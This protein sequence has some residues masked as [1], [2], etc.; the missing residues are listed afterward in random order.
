V[1]ALG[2]FIG[3][4]SINALSDA[5]KD[6]LQMRDSVTR[7]A[8]GV[9]SISVDLREIRSEITTQVGALKVE[10]HE[11]VSALRQEV[12]TQQANHDRRM[13]GLEVRVD[14]VNQRIDTLAASTDVFLSRPPRPAS[15]TAWERG[16]LP[17]PPDSE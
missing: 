10:I 16:C 3:G 15:R 14:G 11:Q 7:L 8:I 13:E 5:H 17:P 12:H 6:R 1:L 2:A 4:R 9:E